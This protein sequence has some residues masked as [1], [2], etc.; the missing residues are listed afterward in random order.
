MLFEGTFLHHR[1]GLGF[2]VTF[3]VP[4][5]ADPDMIAGLKIADLRIA[6]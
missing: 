5:S 6:A 1:D 4:G 3:V 2:V